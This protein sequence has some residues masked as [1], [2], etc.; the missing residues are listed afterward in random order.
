MNV[1]EIGYSYQA[2]FEGFL[3]AEGAGHGSSA[4]QRADLLAR[5]TRRAFESDATITDTM[6]RNLAAAT[7]ALLADLIDTDRA[8]S[9]LP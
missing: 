5:T 1:D 6:L 8:A 9:G 7:V 3:R 2:V 4:E